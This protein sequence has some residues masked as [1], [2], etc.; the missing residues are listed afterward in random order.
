MTSIQKDTNKRTELEA[1]AHCSENSQQKSVEGGLHLECKSGRGR[2]E[3][4]ED[5]SSVPYVGNT[6]SEAKMR[7]TIPI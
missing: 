7:Y 4:N 1:D 6:R 3:V 2:R 5:R